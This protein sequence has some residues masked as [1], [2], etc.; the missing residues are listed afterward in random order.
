LEKIEDILDVWFDSGS[1]WNSVIKSGE[2]DAGEYPTSLYIEGSDQHR[3]WFQASLLL[4]SAINGVSPYK[5]LITHGFT[6][7]AKGEKMSKSKGNVIAPKKVIKQY[8]SEILRLWVA[9]SDYQQDLKISDGILKQTAEQYRKLRNTFRFLLANVDGLEKIV[10]PSEYGELDRWILIKAR[11]VFNSVNS[12][13]AQN[14]FLRGFSTLNNF[15]I[16][17]LSGIYMDITKDRLYCD[18]KDSITRKSTQ[19]AMALIAKSMMA[20]VAPVLTYTIDEILDY[21]PDIIKG[22]MESVFDLVY[23]EI[24]EVEASFDDK[25]LLEARAGLSEVTDR[26][27]KEKIIKSAL[28]LEIIGDIDSFA[29]S[30]KKDLE[31]WF[32]VSALRKS[33]DTQELGSFEVGDKKFK[34][35]KAKDAKCPRCWRFASIDEETTCPRCAEVV[36]LC[37]T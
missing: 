7:D 36:N 1:T 18:D 5:T 37:T 12:S 23:E 31:D 34:L 30:S 20:L 27:K 15:V 6:V 10:E 4:S 24:V 28:E 2:Y 25:E 35:H 3:G 13:F 19:S 29:I 14:D 26:L 33:S 21:A 8:G 17:E 11:E 16:N 32:I 22:D 9:L